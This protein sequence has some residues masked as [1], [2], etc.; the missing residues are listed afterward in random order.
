MN[1]FSKLIDEF[2]NLFHLDPTN[3]A[4]VATG[5]AKVEEIATEV[6]EV[7]SSKG[8]NVSADVALGQEFIKA[9]TT[10]AEAFAKAPAPAPAAAPAPAPVEAPV[11]ESSK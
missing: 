4:D 10:V 1:L 9:A 7:V 6:T 11:S 8:A 3:S 2:K 5:I